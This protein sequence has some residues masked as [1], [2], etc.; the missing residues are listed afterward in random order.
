MIRLKFSSAFAG[1]LFLTGCIHAVERSPTPAPAASAP[2]EQATTWSSA[3]S[4]H[5][6]P[7]VYGASKISPTDAVAPGSARLIFV[8][9]KTA[10]P[11]QPIANIYIGD[12]Y[13][14]SLM[15]GAYVVHTAC[16]GDTRIAAIVDDAGAKHEAKYAANKPYRL[17]AG[18]SY[19]LVLGDR[20]GRGPTTLTEVDPSTVKLSDYKVQTHPVPR[21]PR[22]CQPLASN[23]PAPAPLAAAPA[24]TTAMPVMC[25]VTARGSEVVKASSS[26]DK[27]SIEQLRCAIESWRASWARADFE[28][29]RA[30]YDPQGAAAQKAGWGSFR[31]GRLTK[32]N[33]DIHVSVGQIT[34]ADQGGLVTSEFNQTYRSKQYQ[35]RGVKRLT[36]KRDGGTWTIVN[37]DFAKSGKS[38]KEPA[39]S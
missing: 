7:Y 12:R 29:Y 34:L 23:E 28:T 17:V 36:W 11:D 20:K 35:D 16:A 22:V 21:V 6:D 19:T 4:W 24:A 8:R 37:E 31:N 30:H 33:T 2:D 26:L 5:D 3:N 38:A 25:P 15:P 13:L 27:D 32:S 10:A 1:A 14:S 9:P 18:K 39:K